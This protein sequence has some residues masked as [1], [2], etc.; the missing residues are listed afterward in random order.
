[1]KTITLEDVCELK[2]NVKG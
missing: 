2:E 1:V